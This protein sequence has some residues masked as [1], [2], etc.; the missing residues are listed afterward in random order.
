[1]AVLRSGADGDSFKHVKM[2][3]GRTSDVTVRD[4]TRQDEAFA[5]RPTSLL[6]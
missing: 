5:G 3:G 4:V 2:E 6:A 1:M